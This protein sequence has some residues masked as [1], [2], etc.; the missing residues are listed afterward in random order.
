M[1]R[2]REA[3]EEGGNIR[4]GGGDSDLSKHF[5]PVKKVMNVK[6]SF[7]IEPS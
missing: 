2:W 1:Q 6:P 4:E 5:S 7:D 3:A